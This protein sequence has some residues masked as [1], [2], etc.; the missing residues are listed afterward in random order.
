M[1]L[2]LA[3]LTMKVY[4][5]LCDGLIPSIVSSYGISFAG[6][7]ISAQ[8]NNEVDGLKCDSVVKGNSAAA[9]PVHFMF[10]MYIL[11]HSVLCTITG[12]LPE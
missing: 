6:E 2:T 7:H 5:S 11:R 8:G 1:L 3:D 4:Q 12:V 9:I 10:I